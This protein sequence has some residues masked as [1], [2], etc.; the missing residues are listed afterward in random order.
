MTTPYS[1][2]FSVFLSKIQDD[3]YSTLTETEAEADMIDLLNNAIP[4]F[5]FPKIDIR[6]KDDTAKTFANDLS[7][8][9]INILGNL[10][11]YEWL[12]RQINNIDLLKQRISN[13]DF[14]LTSQSAHLDSLMKL[15]ENTE[16]RIN[17]L[18]RNYSYRQTGSNYNKPDYSGLSGD[19][20]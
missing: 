10:M 17:K 6:D 12:D 14:K 9:E 3:M 1:S 5:E 2:V 13:K 16:K 11:V 4:N 20:E 18:K 15:Q 19:D 7:Q 8:D